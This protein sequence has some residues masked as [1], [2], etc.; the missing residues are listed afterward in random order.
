MRTYKAIERPSQVL[1][2]NLQD[3]LILV[4]IFLG[5][6]FAMGIIGNMITVS[7]WVYLVVI[8]VELALM[9][10][11]RFLSTKKAP[12]YLIAWISFRFFQPRRI[13]VGAFPTPG[14]GKIK[15]PRV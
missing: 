5:S 14:H 2:M 8:L 3:L 15:N 12:G 1:G 13:R 6:V 10:G 9:W 7:R 11:V 4:G